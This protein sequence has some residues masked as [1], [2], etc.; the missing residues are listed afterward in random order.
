M[1]LVKCPIANVMCSLIVGCA[2]SSAD[3][4]PSSLLFVCSF[5]MSEYGVFWRGMCV[6]VTNQ[7]ER[8]QIYTKPNIYIKQNT[9]RNGIMQK[10]KEGKRN[11]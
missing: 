10:L 9:F 6:C 8:L 11:K 2:S 1:T 5:D 3:T 4:I 7:N